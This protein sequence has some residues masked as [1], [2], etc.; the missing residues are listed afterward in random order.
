MDKKIRLANKHFIRT[1]EPSRYIFDYTQQRFKY[2]SFSHYNSIRE[3]YVQKLTCL[4]EDFVAAKCEAH[5]KQIEIEDAKKHLCYSFMEYK[6]HQNEATLEKLRLAQNSYHIIKGAWKTQATE[7]IK[8]RNHI[9]EVERKLNSICEVIP[10]DVLDKCLTRAW[11]TKNAGIISDKKIQERWNAIIATAKEAQ[12]N[13]YG[14]HNG[15][16]R[17]IGESFNIKKLP[18]IA[19]TADHNFIFYYVDKQTHE[20]LPVNIK[21]FKSLGKAVN[22]MLISLTQ[23]EG[24]SVEDIG[25]NFSFKAEYKYF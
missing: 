20:M 23:E 14:L 9:K 7:V 13:R 10:A 25:R 4:R 16:V 22:G 21:T 12:H 2:V 11:K 19:E 1:E 3:D 17:I 8:I 24:F 18:M 6:S 5:H 15:Y